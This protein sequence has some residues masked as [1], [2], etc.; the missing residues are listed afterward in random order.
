MK[1]L[2]LAAMLAAMPTLAWAETTDCRAD[3]QTT[4]RIRI[5]QEKGF[6]LR[7][8]S[9]RDWIRLRVPYQGSYELHV[10]GEDQFLPT[11]V[12][13]RNG[14]VQ[15]G[16]STGRMSFT[17]SGLEVSELWACVYSPDGHPGRYTVTLKRIRG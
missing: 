5:G 2:L 10:K 9:D 1:P 4:C 3:T 7:R 15:G 6:L 16:P 14:G 11:N 12:C 17:P 13:G 8:G